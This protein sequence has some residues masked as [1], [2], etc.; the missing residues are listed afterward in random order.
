[1]YNGLEVFVIRLHSLFES[2]FM[3]RSIY[4]LIIA[5][6]MFQPFASAEA[7][8]LAPGTL[9]KA[10][11][12]AVYYFH[13]NGTRFVF[14]NEKTYFTWY[15]GFSNI[16]TLTDT[17]L[18]A[19]ALGG[20]VTYRPGLKLIKLTTDP[21]TYAVQGNELRWVQNESLAIEL[22]GSTWASK[23]DD[24]P[25]AFFAD[26]ELGENIDHATDYTP[27]TIMTS[28]PTIADLFEAAPPPPPPPPPPSG[29]SL[30]I[31]PNK[32]EAQANESVTLLAQTDYAGS[33]DK[34][35]IYVNGNLYFSCSAT[36]SCTTT[37]LIPTAG[38]AN[39]YMY[40]VKLIT[41]NQGS[42]E[43]SSQTTI[44]DAP[45]HPS[46]QIQIDRTQIKP[47]SPASIRSVVLQGLV[48]AKNEIVIDGIAR[49]VCT[50]NPGD[51]YFNDFIQ[52]GIGSIHQV[53]SRVETPAGLKYKSE[54][55]TITIA[56]NDTPMITLTSAKGEIYAYET[57]DVTTSV[58]DDDGVDFVE[59]WYG[60]SVL[61]HCIGAAPC[62]AT[63][64][65]FTG[66]PSGSI[67]KFDAMAVDMLGATGTASGAYVLIK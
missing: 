15:S 63:A 42:F 34:M 54:T 65:P 45:I 35:E 39:S 38:T 11:G 21:K 22:Y 59:I 50:T 1:M 27:S 46:I 9:I 41:M 3:K 52:G 6:I 7:V 2:I 60:G 16:I 17:E 24:L 14:P 4:T 28:Y 49:K 12:P 23:V 18:A 57:V 37:W 66:K 25:D 40:R 58:S 8:T 5:T 48:A 43:A 56:E 29:F 30:T 64:G 51:C 33:I 13:D 26:Y 19:I 47:T 61:K 32:T 67:L 31:T 20:N 62:T 53:Y 36:L 10:S 55:K 44:V